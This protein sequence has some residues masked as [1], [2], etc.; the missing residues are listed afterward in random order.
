MGLTQ[1]KA[2]VSTNTINYMQP[3]AAP[4]QPQLARVMMPAQFQPTGPAPLL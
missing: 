3:S 1:Q 2:N 4:A